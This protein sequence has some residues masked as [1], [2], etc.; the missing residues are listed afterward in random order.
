MSV[1]L[2][3]PFG[4]ISPIRSPS[5]IV[6]GMFL[7]SGTAPN[8]F[9]SP[10]AVI[11]GIGGNVRSFLRIHFTRAAVLCRRPAG[12]PSLGR[13][14]IRRTSVARSVPRPTTLFVPRRIRINARLCLSLVFKNIAGIFAT[15]LPHSLV[16]KAEASAPTCALVSRSSSRWVLAAAF[17]LPRSPTESSSF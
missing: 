5:E 12:V 9:E 16:R 15:R 7:K 11:I 6:N 8:R 14:A 2:P 4:P 17:G 3:D 1:D 13:P 10:C